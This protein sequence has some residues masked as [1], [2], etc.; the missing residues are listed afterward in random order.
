MDPDIAATKIQK[1][2]TVEN[3]LKLY[4]CTLF[5]ELTGNSWT[6]KKCE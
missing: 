4:I 6:R 5:D 2:S 3:Y 1:V